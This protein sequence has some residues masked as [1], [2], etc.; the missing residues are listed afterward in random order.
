MVRV[1]LVSLAVALSACSTTQQAAPVGKARSGLVDYSLLSPG[2]EGQAALRYV[3]P[4]AQWSRYKK[5]M[6]LPVTFWAGDKSMPGKDHTLSTH[7]YYH[8]LHQQMS[9]KF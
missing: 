2:A 3:N 8:S 7:K 6:I 1:V 4:S 5:I 9:Q